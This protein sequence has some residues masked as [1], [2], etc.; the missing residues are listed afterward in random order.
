M[1]DSKF[2]TKLMIFAVL[3]VVSTAWAFD[4]SEIENKIV[5]YK[6]DNGLTIIVLPRHDAPVVSF[7][8]NVNTGVADDPK[9]A[10]GL[11]HMFEHMAFKGTEE[12]GSKDLKKEM[13]WMAE[14]DRIFELIL[15]ERS[16]GDLADSAK[17][18]ELEADMALAT[19]SAFAYSETNEFGK[20]ADRNGGV[21]LNAGTSFDNTAY[22]ISF[23]SNKL[24]LWM[25]MESDRFHKPVLRELFKEKQVVA[26]ERRYRVES[27][28]IGRMVNEYLGL[29][30]ISHP[31][32][33]PLIGEMSE[34]Q[35]YNRP[36]MMEQFNKYYIPRNMAIGIVG[37]VDPEE[38]Y[39]LA[40]KYFGRLEDKPKPRPQW[41]EE[42]E[43]F[44]IRKSTIVEKSQPMVI[45]GYHVPSRVHPDWVALNA[46]A[47]YLGSG[48]TSVFYKELVKDKKSAVAVETFTG[49]PG[50]KYPSLFSVLCV[51][52]NESSNSENET[53]ILAEIDKVRTELIPES[54][55]EK[56]K[57]Q[58]KAG[59]INGLASNTGMAS[60]LTRYQLSHGD[61]RELFNYLDKVNALTTD[62]IK[63]VAET[64]LDPEKRFAV[65]IEKP[66]E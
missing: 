64:Y 43:S 1:R 65:Y 21:G 62:D 49:Y 51:P 23:P 18:A 20:I 41:I 4:F 22:Y 34:I 31:Y 55:L 44:G 8:T 48:R 29:A 10:T 61:W 9:G 11:A 2:L 42:Q 47:G 38:V 13:N 40:Q 3:M 32:G 28:P 53:A 37:D 5:E 24:E 25:A 46:L 45:F 15:D 39:K 27:M 50:S 57:A 63:R 35:D 26:E 19:D 7:V 54:E 59:M 36:V 6:L 17:L 14:E 56:I 52:S 60:R 33:Q 66:E 30:Y 58:A 12:I 16:K